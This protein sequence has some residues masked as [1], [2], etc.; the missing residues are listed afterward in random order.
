MDLELQ[1]P[2]IN[3][4]LHHAYPLT[5]AMSHKDFNSWFLSNYIQLEYS[6]QSK[7]I[8]FLTYPICGTSCLCPLLDYKILDL[9]FIYISNIDIFDFIKTSI[10][11][12]YYVMTYTDEFS[13]PERISYVRKIHFRH[14]IMIYGYDSDKS[15]FNVIGYNEKLK[16]TSS[17][18]SFSEFEFY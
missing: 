12:G 10:N 4:Y 6:V 1:Q 18:V 9:E 5:V 7:T 14:D 3:C 8:N 15:L 13:I 16:Y 2:P 11:L 17:C